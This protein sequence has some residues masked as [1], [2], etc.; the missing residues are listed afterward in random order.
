MA[1]PSL[2]IRDC[3]RG[4]VTCMWRHPA[5]V[6]LAFWL[7]YLLAFPLCLRASLAWKIA[8]GLL[9]SLAA[10]PCACAWHRRIIADEPVI[11][12]LG[13][14]E[15]NF[16]KAELSILI[17]SLAALFLSIMAGIFVATIFPHWSTP[18]FFMV[19]GF[20]ATCWLVAPMFLGLP[21]A[22][23]GHRRSAAQLDAAA[24]PHRS[25]R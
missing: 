3:L 18:L 9:S 7:V 10:V 16:V 21:A 25:N 19:L 1:S 4:A 20:V 8:I 15:W 22:A 23:L 24:A 6:L 5:D 12:T 14:P 17:L 11:L 13:R 2:S